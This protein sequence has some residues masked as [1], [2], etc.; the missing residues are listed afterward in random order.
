MAE[1]GAVAGEGAVTP[2]AA[3]LGS[4]VRCFDADGEHLY[5]LVCPGDANPLQGLISVASP[6]GRALLGRAGGEEIDIATPGGVRVLT[7]L[8]VRDGEVR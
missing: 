4:S 7:I 3:G 6:V 5:T 1:R 8:S 2:V